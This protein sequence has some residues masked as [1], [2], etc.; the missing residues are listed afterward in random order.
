[1]KSLFNTLLLIAVF[2][3]GFSIQITYSQA[4]LSIQG[5]IKKS[6][7]KAVDD[8][9]YS[10]T[11]A[12]YTTETG[13]VA[14][15]S[16]NQPNLDVTGGIYSALL[17]SINPLTAAFN[18]P[19]FLG[20]KVGTGTELTPRA[21]LTSS[22]Y[23]LSLIGQ[24]NTFPSSGT[25]GVGTA[26]PDNAYKLHVKDKALL[27][28]TTGEAK[29]YLKGNS[30]TL[31]SIGFSTGSADMSIH[32]GGS[33]AV[34][35]P[36]AIKLTGNRTI[37]GDGE[38]TFN[39]IGNTLFN[40]AGN[41]KL[42]VTNAGAEAP[43]LFTNNIKAINNDLFLYP[44]GGNSNWVRLYN[45]NNEEVM[46]TIS[47][48]LLVFK[49]IEVNGSLQGAVTNGTS[50]RFYNSST[51]G[52]SSVTATNPWSIICT[53]RIK[54]SEFDAFSDR[55]IKKDLRLSN[56]TGDLST[57]LQL[58]VTDYKHIDEVTKGTAFK[59]GFIA[60]EVETV[61]PEAVSQSTEFVPDVFANAMSSRLDGKNLTI[62]MDKK[63]LLAVG[64]LVRL[65]GEKGEKRLTVSAVTSENTF[66]VAEWDEANAPEWIFVF[67]KQ[68]KYFRT[69]DYD[70][71][72]T[73]NVSATQELARQ[74]E[75]LQK[76]NRELKARNGEMKSSLEGIEGRL[77]KMEASMSN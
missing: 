41:T 50:Y 24:S 31:G 76:E 28:S 9:T 48:R 55:R 19:Y 26:S 74:V 60:Q 71:I 10:V 75:A 46:R 53:E 72:H 5:V 57:L 73:L 47:D 68:V 45:G 44:A 16:E 7:G 17:G 52:N 15:W 58:R 59:K 49:M 34:S 43:E 29:M 35:F 61:F 69:V 56:N 51:T 2:L 65:V 37:T 39:S 40:F 30:S 12:L 42:K 67:G 20:V 22:P 62:N 25:V 33:N 3:C 63:H 36:S 23:A 13:G 1:M 4:T 6:D 38:M 21:R 70:R 14:V 8:G 11:F 66:T 64:D 54:A 77:K 27:E 32:A 18:Q